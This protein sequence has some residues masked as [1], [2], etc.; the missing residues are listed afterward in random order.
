LVKEPAVASN[1]DAGRP[2]HE[3]PGHAGASLLGC[4]DLKMTQRYAHL[5][6]AM[7]RP[8]GFTPSERVPTEWPKVLES[9]RSAL[10]VL[11]PP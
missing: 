3:S 1:R 9:T 7:E 2:G 11:T 10:Q 4:N 6:E 8:E 5:R